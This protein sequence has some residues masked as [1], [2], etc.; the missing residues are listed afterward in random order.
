MHC[1][2]NPAGHPAGSIHYLMQMYKRHLTAVRDVQPDQP[3][4]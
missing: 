1:K 3:A 2:E 4:S